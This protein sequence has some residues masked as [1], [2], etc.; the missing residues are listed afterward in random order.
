MLGATFANDRDD[1]D[2]DKAF[3]YL[4]KAMTSRWADPNDPLTKPS[5]SPIAA[6]DFRTECETPE[7]LLAIQNDPHALHM[8]GLVIRERILGKGPLG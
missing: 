5:V 1:Y 7:D 4:M 3:H 2:I 8:E 6:Y